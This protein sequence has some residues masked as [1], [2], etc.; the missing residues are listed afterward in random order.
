[1][2]KLPITYENFD[3]EEVTEEHYFH[4][5]MQELSKLQ[6]D[7]PPG[8]RLSDKLQKI[9]EGAVATDIMDT[10]NHLV[11]LSYGTREGGST[12]TK[13][14]AI[15]R[16]FMNSLAFDAMFAKMMTD[17]EYTVQ[18]VKGFV[19]SA[20]LN[21]PEAKKAIEESGLDLDS[22]GINHIPAL[23]DQKEISV[24]STRITDD[25]PPLGSDAES[26]LAIPRDDN[27][28][29]LPW[30]FRKPTQ[31]ELMEMNHRQLQDVTRRMNSPWTPPTTS[32]S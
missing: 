26:G 30:A 6:L 8:E 1:M 11:S 19:P 9:V 3:G 25:V 31:K 21:S 13:D 32:P 29:F 22:F 2:I 18:F 20:L 12:F 28:I 10:I 24:E 16:Q 14:D 4:M 23:S 7:P 27:G 5:N 15:T 17:G